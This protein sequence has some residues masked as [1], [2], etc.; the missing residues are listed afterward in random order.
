MLHSSDARTASILPAL[1]S[2]GLLNH[3]EV[4]A[5]KATNSR[6]VILIKYN[7]NPFL[8]TLEEFLQN[9]KDDY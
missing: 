8:L 4:V 5:S 7:S 1:V 6:L 9:E 3:K 2:F